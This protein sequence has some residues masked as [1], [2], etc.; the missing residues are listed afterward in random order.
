MRKTLLSLLAWASISVAFAQTTFVVD[1]ITYTVKEG[2]TEV[3]LTKFGEEAKKITDLVIPSSVTYGDVKYS[4]TSIADDESKSEDPVYGYGNAKTIKIPGSVKRV[5]N[6]TFYRCSLTSI[7]LGNGVEEIGVYAFSG[8]SLEQLEIPGSVKVIGADAFFGSSSAQKLKKL[9]LH[10]GLE[11]IGDAAF[12][13]HGLEELE[14]P[15]SVKKIGKNAFAYVGKLKKLTLNEGL[16]EIGDG[17]FQNGLYTWQ[18]TKDLTSITLPSTLKKIGSEAFLRVPLTAINIPASVEEIGESAFAKTNITKYIVDPKNPNFMVDEEYGALFS[19]DGSI[20]YSIPMTGV[21]EMEL[22]C[23]GIF[24][25]AFWGSEIKRVELSDGVK[26]IWDDAFVETA[27]EHISLPNTI[28]YIGYEAFAGTKLKEVVLP[29]SLF[30]I[31]QRCFAACSELTSVVIPSSVQYIDNSA[32]VYCNKL[33]SVTCKGS[34]PPELADAYDTDYYIFS[35]DFTLYVPKGCKDTYAATQIGEMY[36]YWPNYYANIVETSQG[37]IKHVSCAPVYASVLDASQTAEFQVTFAD[38]VT[39]IDALPAVG[40][41]KDAPYNASMEFEGG[42]TA[43][44]SGKT[45]TVTAKNGADET[46]SFATEKEHVYYIT[47]PAGV[48]KNAAGDQNECIVLGYYGYG[49][50]TGIDQT[51]KSGTLGK[52]SVVARYNINGQQT[53]APQKG[54]QI[55]RLSDG[56]IRKVVVK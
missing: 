21:T 26:V 55:V 27:L 19:K 33:A 39:C 6:Y 28:T 45:L 48:V 53:T 3:E 22:N 8:G 51:L 42:W 11:E 31:D 34:N 36:N 49:Y 30:F 47:I 24:G 15:G 29:E 13:G 1:D 56:S 16:E 10:E 23:A 46:A 41:R 2:T 9:T 18:N 44:V 50:E 12:W 5:G 17:A 52:G 54:L 14:I 38:D 43:S 25:G 32:F 35:S 4:V 40:V 37:I 20:L 7:M